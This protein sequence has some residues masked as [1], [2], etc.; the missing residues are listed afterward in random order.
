[1][2]SLASGSVR[3]SGYRSL[4]ETQWTART[5]EGFAE[6]REGMRSLLRAAQ[7]PAHTGPHRETQAQLLGSQSRG[8]LGGPR[9]LRGG[10]ALASGP[11]PWPCAVNYVLPLQPSLRKLSGAS[12]PPSWA[13]WVPATARPRPLLAPVSAGLA[14][15]RGLG[16]LPT[17]PQRSPAFT[18]LRGV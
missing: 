2:P 10:F 8:R 12:C 16:C 3:P 6:L 1:M 15:T 5:E 7:R 18:C 14:D 13:M 17:W 4:G 11:C 9:R